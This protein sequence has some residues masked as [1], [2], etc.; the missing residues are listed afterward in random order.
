MK[1]EVFRTHSRTFTCDSLKYSFFFF[2]SK[3]FK[4]NKIKIMKVFSIVLYCITSF[5]LKF[6]IL[7]P[8]E[9]TDHYR[10]FVV[11]TI[12]S[13]LTKWCYSYLGWEFKKTVCVHFCVCLY[14]SI[15][16]TIEMPKTI[17][18]AI[19]NFWCSQTQGCYLF[20]VFFSPPC[21]F[22]NYFL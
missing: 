10:Q 9:V 1:W 15:S 16:F 6:Y 3:N 19:L 12:R 14:F 4:Q 13:N 2:L 8:Y 11:L 21:K 7:A 17:L 18:E 22:P 20:L 5:C